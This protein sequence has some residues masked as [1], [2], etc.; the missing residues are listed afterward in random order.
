MLANL[1]PTGVRVCA[2]A[3]LLP[4]LAATAQAGQLPACPTPTGPAVQMIRDA[5][6]VTGEFMALC[7]DRVLVTSGASA[8]V[9]DTV[10]G[11]TVHEFAE[12][13]ASPLGYLRGRNAMYYQGA[14]YP[15]TRLFEY[16][17]DTGEKREFLL[18]RPVY[19]VVA[20][21][22]NH[23]VVSTAISEYKQFEGFYTRYQ[24][25]I[26]DPGQGTL[27]PVVGG[28][29]GIPANCSYFL[30]CGFSKEADRGVGFPLGNHF[31]AGLNEGGG[32]WRAWGTYTLDPVSLAIRFN[33]SI[34]VQHLIL[35]W[36][37]VTPDGGRVMEMCGG[38]V[39]HYCYADVPLGD[40]SDV[41]QSNTYF[42]QP[43]EISPDG[44]YLLGADG[45]YGLSRRSAP[46]TYL[47]PFAGF[48]NE[49]RQAPTWAT[50]SPDGRYLIGPYWDGA[51]SRYKLL[52]QPL[53]TP[54]PVSSAV[55]LPPEVLTGPVATAAYF[56]TAPV[57]RHYNANGQARTVTTV[58]AIDTPAG[59]EV[60]VTSTAGRFTYRVD[61]TG[62]Y[63]ARL[64][65]P[66]AQ[67]AGATVQVLQEFSP[68]I[69]V[70]PA[71][72]E[73]GSTVTTSGL[74]RVS[75]AGYGEVNV[76]YEAVMAVEGRTRE[77]VAG[78]LRP[79]LQVYTQYHFQGTLAEVPFAVLSEERQWYAEDLGMVR[80]TALSPT[81]AEDGQVLV[82][83]YASQSAAGGEGGGGGGAAG[84]WLL[85]GLV[86]L[87][88]WRRRRT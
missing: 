56:P 87:W 19:A 27:M 15:L 37:S 76:P 42:E 67:V 25:E 79:L 44:Q 64:E 21:V 65:I 7:G 17:L 80:S 32:T 2:V 8:R 48:A 43:R 81:P 35:K 24:M 31:V 1:V 41:L 54:G 84:P 60:L 71:T 50:F 20:A 38:S 11:A 10:T 70:L 12:S 47:D 66:D 36:L 63:L 30:Y 52:Y 82:S 51:E 53:P 23:F 33:G 4:G 28:D 49:N 61:D 6:G 58:S 75:A 59:R 88:R 40:G 85:L 18:P 69:P 3:F 34:P 46:T 26:F 13:G 73:V 39:P 45:G 57:A 22:G 5:N 14:G 78:S 72:A 9:V 29:F 62:V 68:A 83:T 77:M 74:V 16:D 55:Q 86:A